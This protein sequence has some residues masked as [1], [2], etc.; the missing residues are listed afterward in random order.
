[1]LGHISEEEKGCLLG[2]WYD[3]L[4]RIA[5]LLHRTWERS[6]I[7][8]RS[9]VV[10]KGNDSSTWNV[11]AGAW[12]RAREGWIAVVYALGI[13]EILERQCPGKVLR[14]MAADVAWWHTNSGGDLDP[15]T[16]VWAELPLPWE[17]LS[18]EADCPRSLVEEICRKH[19][20]DPVKKGWAAPRPG[21][22]VQAFRPTPELVHGVEVSSP[23]LAGLLRRAGWFSARP[24]RAVAK[25]VVVIRD[26]LGFALGATEATPARE[27]PDE[28]G[29]GPEPG[30]S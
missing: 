8:R 27:G 14:L 2:M 17:V 26:L 13:D 9:M 28:K 4:F 11:T 23:E 15:D 6:N 18:G 25:D 7:N 20:V 16:K 5:R 12:N 22:S 1:V 30:G 19:E 29:A 3:V 24:G 21:R 10:R